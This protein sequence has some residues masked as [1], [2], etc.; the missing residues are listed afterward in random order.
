MNNMKGKRFVS[1]DDVETQVFP[2]GR[3][4]WLSEPRVTGT[5]NMT[6]GVV[7]LMPGK[8]HDRHN[9]ENCEEILF[10]IEG[11]GD[12]TVEVEGRVEKKIIKKGDLVHIPPS[13]FHST[14]NIGKKS[15]VLFA[16]YQFPG[17]EAFLRSLPQCIIEPP[18]NKPI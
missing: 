2:W 6:A 12:Q 17:P 18:K 9:H 11:E 4:S 13:A 7:I 16:V 15:M 3:L 10:V 8:G 14:I 1:V 5:D